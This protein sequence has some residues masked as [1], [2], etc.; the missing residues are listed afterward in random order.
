MSMILRLEAACARALA[1]R[2]L[3]SVLDRQALASVE[4]STPNPLPVHPNIR[5]KAYYH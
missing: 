1:C 5:G 4:Q 2:A 3:S